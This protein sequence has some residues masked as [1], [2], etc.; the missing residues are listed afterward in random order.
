MLTETWLSD[1]ISD[2]SKI[3]EMTPK[4]HAFHHIPR[5]NR[6][7]GG[8][9]VFLSKSFKKVTVKKCKEVNSFEYIDMD[10]SLRNL[11]I[12]IIVIYRPPNTNKS[13]SK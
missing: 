6:V 8:V 11:N 4:T 7:G 12:R 2:N 3:T 9:G 1:N 10:A 13:V 5:Q